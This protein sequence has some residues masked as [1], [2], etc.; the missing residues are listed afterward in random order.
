MVCLVC[1][2]YDSCLPLGSAGCSI[3]YH[4]LHGILKRL[5]SVTSILYVNLYPSFRLPVSV[6]ASP[7]LPPVAPYTKLPLC[8]LVT[9]YC[10]ILHETLIMWRRA[11]QSL[12]SSTP[13]AHPFHQSLSG[14][15]N[16]AAMVN[17]QCSKRTFMICDNKWQ[18]SFFRCAAQMWGAKSLRDKRSHAAI[19]SGYVVRTP[20]F[21]T[22]TKP[23]PR[24]KIVYLLQFLHFQLYFWKVLVSFPPLCFGCS[25]G[26]LVSSLFIDWTFANRC[27]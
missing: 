20:M 26:Q 18:F 15:N 10:S 19:S 21:S 25:C 13:C 3:S 17:R 9:A 12:S 27:F 4:I 7:Q 24:A 8:I 14:T 5:S 2:D 1:L 16:R 22:H 6:K 23:R 11:G